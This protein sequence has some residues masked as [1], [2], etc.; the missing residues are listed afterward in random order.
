MRKR[1][2]C[3]NCRK[4]GGD[5]SGDNLLLFEGSETHGFCFTCNKTQ[6]TDGEPVSRSRRNDITNTQNI[7]IIKSYPIRALDTRGITKETCEHFHVKVSVDEQTGEVCKHYYPYY[8]GDNVSNYKIRTLP[9][10]FS[11]TG[12]V[13]GLFG[14]KSCKQNAKLLL[15][16]EGEIDAMSAWQMIKAQGKNYN[17]VSIP[18]GSNEAGTIDQEIRKQLDWITAHEVVV[19]CL[20]SDAP[21]Q[22]TTKGLAELIVS[23]TKVRIMKLPVKDANQMLL[24]KR[25]KEFWECLLNAKEFHPTSIV[26]GS[27]LSLEV[28]KKPKQKGYSLPYPK[29]DKMVMGLR[30]GEIITITGAPGGG[31]TA[32]ATELMYHLTKFHGLKTATIALETP[33]VDAAKKYIAMDNNIPAYRFIFHGD[34]L[35][36]QQIEKSRKEV[37]NNMAFMEHWGSID[38]D[39]LMNRINFYAKALQ[40]DFVLIDHLSM[41]VAGLDTD[42]RKALDITMERLTKCVTST[43]VGIINVI[44]LKRAHGKSFAK[45]DEIELTDMRGTS[46]VEA[47]S[48]GVW[49]LERDQQADDAKKDIVKIRVIKNRQLGF[50]GLADHCVYSHETG[51]ITPMQVEY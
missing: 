12:K 39:T 42:E 3:S 31:K 1:V 19:L 38:S 50:T 36:D 43:G 49:A 35:T 40:I 25:E 4:N 10:T 5:R 46:G 13:T 20:D 9:K 44:H 17:C 2:A 51:R 11:A 18:N 24:E 30:K 22:A 21:G 29:L 33:M 32:F 8:E 41:T 37:I 26:E 15:I 27:S 28:L 45:G 14:Q 7:E 23:D 47:M 16:C 6:T 34:C 48:W